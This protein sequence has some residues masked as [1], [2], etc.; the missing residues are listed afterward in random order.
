MHKMKE[1]VRTT[2][3]GHDIFKRFSNITCSTQSSVS[4]QS[5][6]FN[7][8]CSS[9]NDDECHFKD[10]EDSHYFEYYESGPL[11]LLDA[12]KTKEAQDQQEQKSNEQKLARSIP[13]AGTN[14]NRDYPILPV[15]SSMSSGVRDVQP[16]DQEITIDDAMKSIVKS[17]DSWAKVR[18]RIRSRNLVTN[19]GVFEVCLSYCREEVD[20]LKKERIDEAAKAEAQLSKISRLRRRLSLF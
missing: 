17:S 18:E 10:E 20:R 16:Q 1:G 19:Q 11:K 6:R 4:V 3:Q 14:T 2:Q 12:F 15:S 8:D 9:E 13:I 7:G 5:N